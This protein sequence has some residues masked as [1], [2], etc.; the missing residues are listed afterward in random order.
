MDNIKN[1]E[2]LAL[3]KKNYALK[4][5]DKLKEYRKQYYIKNVERIRLQGMDIQKKERRYNLKQR[6][7]RL[8]L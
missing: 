5:K 4:H 1:A 7:K 8:L 6:K 2:K 3:I